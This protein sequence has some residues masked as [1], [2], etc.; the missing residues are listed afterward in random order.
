MD[1]KHGWV[2]IRIGR[3]GPQ[4]SEV[5]EV[6]AV[7]IPCQEELGIY[8]ADATIQISAFNS[9]RRQRASSQRVYIIITCPSQ[10]IAKT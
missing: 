5:M 3:M 7:F 2:G 9:Y 4:D 10:V 8:Q 6:R 1:F